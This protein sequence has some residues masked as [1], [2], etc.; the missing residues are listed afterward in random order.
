MHFHP[1]PSIYQMSRIIR[2]HF[3][4]QAHIVTHDNIDP[5][6]FGRITIWRPFFTHPHT[7]S[8]TLVYNT[9]PYIN[10]I[11]FYPIRLQM[12]SRLHSWIYMYISIYCIREKETLQVVYTNDNDDEK[13]RKFLRAR[14]YLLS[15]PAREKL[16]C[17]CQ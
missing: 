10:Y 3:V 11:T 15:A 16:P 6:R 8:K 2:I 4:S 13:R 9:I 1:L 17:A 5:A 14:R 7:Q 12:F